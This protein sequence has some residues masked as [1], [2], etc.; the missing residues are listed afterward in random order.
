[1]G[2]YSS[3]FKSNQNER[4]REPIKTTKLV[5]RKSFRDSKKVNHD[6]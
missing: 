6:I 2:E 4:G 3:Y 5:D 1:M